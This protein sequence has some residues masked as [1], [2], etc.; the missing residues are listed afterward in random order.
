[1]DF[2]FFSGYC[3]IFLPRHGM[4]TVLPYVLSLQKAGPVENLNSWTAGI[5]D[6]EAARTKKLLSIE[7][8]NPFIKK[9]D[10]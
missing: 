1:M 7:D 8:T 2:S 10:P 5:F 9:K 3:I 6:F 4:E